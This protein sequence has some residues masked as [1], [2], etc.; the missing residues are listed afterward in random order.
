MDVG[1]RLRKIRTDRGLSQADLAAPLFTHAY[2]SSIESGRR[3]A[4]RRAL[5]HFASRLGV[6]VDELQTGRPPGLA[7]RLELALQ[8]GRHLVSSGEI[9]DAEALFERVGREAKRYLE[10]RLQAYAEEG[11][12]LCA[13]RRGRL[14]EA[15]DLC[16]GARDLLAEEPPTARAPVVARLARCLHMRGDTRY[17]IYLIEALLTEL[18]QEGLEDPSTS[19][20]LYG[21]LSLFCFDAGL[22]AQAD[23]AAQEALRLAG[24]T[25][26]SLNLAMMYVNVARV[27]LNKKLYDDAEA[28]LVKAEALFRELDLQTE[29]AVA[30]LAHGYVLSRK[31]DTLGAEVQLETAREIFQATGSAINEAH[32][33]NELAKLLRERGELDRARP[34][35]HRSIELVAHESDIRV[36]AW[37]QRELGRCDFESDPT[38]AEKRLRSA[39]EL[40]ER[41]EE[42]IELAVTYGDL[43]DLLN[44]QDDGGGCDLYRQAV[45]VIREIV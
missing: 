5:E 8:R 30:R 12:A 3:R 4:S 17:A 45:G 27:Q 34:L 42:R 36:L 20:L 18:K 7:V 14:E 25:P 35:L 28:S 16:E 22:Y 39:A 26:N 21:P 13:E 44:R 2:V 38:V 1:R 40:Y 43:G 32:A 15:I 29:M 41:A 37:A 23:F 9:D 33:S 6:E 31:G 24:S 10:I 19:V 11:K